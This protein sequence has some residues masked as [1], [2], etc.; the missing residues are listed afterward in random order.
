MIHSLTLPTPLKAGIEVN[1]R[2]NIGIL[3]KV[4]HHFF[5]IIFMVWD[6]GIFNKV[7]PDS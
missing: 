5:L 3:N 6:K 1:N 2:F 7:P 4:I